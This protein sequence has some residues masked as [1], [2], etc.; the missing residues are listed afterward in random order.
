M[1]MSCLYQVCVDCYMLDKSNV[2]VVYCPLPLFLPLTASNNL[3]I[4]G[5]GREGEGEGGGGG[6]GAVS[7]KWR[8]MCG[9]KKRKTQT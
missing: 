3:Y 5:R 8:Q 1:V 9:Q 6:G 4:R 2:V 7:G